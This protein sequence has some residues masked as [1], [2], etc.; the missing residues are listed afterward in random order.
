MN[1]INSTKV[2]LTVDGGSEIAVSPSTSFSLGVEYIMFFDEIDD[3][4]RIVDT[5]YY[6]TL[7]SSLDSTDIEN[8][9]KVSETYDAAVTAQEAAETDIENKSQTRVR[10]NALLFIAGLFVIILLIK[11]KILHL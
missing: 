1:T 5:D 9:F 6:F 7:L 8:I 2:I 3:D 11:G 10:V 4:Y